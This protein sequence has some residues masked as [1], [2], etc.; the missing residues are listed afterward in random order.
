MCIYIIVF[1]CMYVCIASG[2]AV[3]LYVLSDNFNAYMSLALFRFTV[4]S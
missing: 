1:V 4:S 3:D 2:I